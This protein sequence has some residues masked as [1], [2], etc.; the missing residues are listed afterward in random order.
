[1]NCKFGLHQGVALLE[2]IA[3][4]PRPLSLDNLKIKNPLATSSTPYRKRCKFL[5]AI[6]RADL[7]SGT[8]REESSSAQ[9]VRKF[10]KTET[11]ANE[12]PGQDVADM[13]DVFDVM[14]EEEIEE[15]KRKYILNFVK[16]VP[17]LQMY[18]GESLY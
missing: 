5:E 12:L 3:K 18:T 8:P 6:P 14:T 15:W 11:G 1:M 4:E 7:G 2:A 16:N 13:R 17:S 9:Q 10:R